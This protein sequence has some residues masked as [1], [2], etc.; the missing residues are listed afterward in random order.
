M[1]R[2]V[3]GSCLIQWMQSG[4]GL[5]ERCISP[6]RLV[7][8]SWLKRK[9]STLLNV[10]FWRHLELAS[11]GFLHSPSA[12]PFDTISHS[13]LL[14]LSFIPLLCLYSCSSNG[15]EAPSLTFSISSRLII[16]QHLAEVQTPP[17]SL[18]RFPQ[19]KWLLFPCV[20][21]GFCYVHFLW[22]PHT[23]T[24]SLSSTVPRECITQSNARK[25]LLND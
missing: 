15:Q 20:S 14:L 24:L 10:L 1:A 5:E 23:T 11:P 3:G 7:V 21:S 25:R 8:P 6:K 4:Q 9:A 16:L 17:S 12:L 19:A 18:P 13:Y 22:L 2:G